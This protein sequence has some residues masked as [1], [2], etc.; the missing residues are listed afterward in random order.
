MQK[1]DIGALMAIFV[2]TFTMPIE[3]VMRRLQ[4][5]E[6]ILFVHLWPLTQALPLFP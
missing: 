1:A 2:M 5:R 3:V 4:V 6:E